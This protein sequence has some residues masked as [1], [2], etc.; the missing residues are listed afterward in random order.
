[1]EAPLWNGGQR[2]RA[3]I[4]AESID[5]DWKRV[6]RLAGATCYKRFTYIRHTVETRVRLVGKRLSPAAASKK[7]HSSA[8]V[9][10]P[11][12]YRHS[13]HLQLLRCI[14]VLAVRCEGLQA[15]HSKHWQESLSAGDDTGN[16]QAG[17]DMEK[18]QTS[19][20]G[21][22]EGWRGKLMLQLQLCDGVK[23]QIRED[24]RRVRTDTYAAQL[25]DLN[26]CVYCH[27][28]AHIH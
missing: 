22:E 21:N 4:R 5:G 13:S 12:P 9:R 27:P 25:S 3:R 26:L 16:T 23:L 15:V 20:K 10:S 6:T 28:P 11:P 19:R 24:N 2:G 14:A 18:E 8:H 7:T 17:I 1:M